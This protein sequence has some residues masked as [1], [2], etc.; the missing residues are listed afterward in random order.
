MRI[1]DFCIGRFTHHSTSITFITLA[2]FFSACVSSV[3]GFIEQVK[4]D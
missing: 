4:G 3:M 2:V 1:L